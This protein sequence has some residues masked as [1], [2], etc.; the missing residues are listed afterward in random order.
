[1]TLIPNKNRKVSPHAFNIVNTDLEQLDQEVV[2]L[3]EIIAEL[4][5]KINL[6]E[7]KLNVKQEE[8]KPIIN[9]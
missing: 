1:M 9:K 8:N 7:A 3:I 4:Q 5:N 6:L 2:K